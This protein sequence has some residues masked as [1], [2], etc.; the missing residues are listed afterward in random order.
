LS[1]KLLEFSFEKKSS[2]KINKNKFIQNQFV[3]FFEKNAV[4]VEQFELQADLLSIIEKFESSKFADRYNVQKDEDDYNK[5]FIAAKHD[6][7]N[8]C[9]LQST[10]K[11]LNSSTN[12]ND[13]GIN[14]NYNINISLVL[15]DQN[16]SESIESSICS[17]AK[18]NF[19][20]KSFFKNDII[21]DQI[22]SLNS[23]AQED[24]LGSL[25]DNSLSIVTT[26]RTGDETSVVA[27]YDFN[28]EKDSDLTF[29]KGDRIQ[30]L[31][32]QLNGWWVGRNIRTLKCGYFPSNFITNK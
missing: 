25:G 2:E 18:N 8:S 21:G 28:A 29:E 7:N 27:A 19:K 17:A 10:S 6:Y 14:S 20:L 9:Q 32:R 22:S 4:I 12:S 5:D 26:N 13:V 1:K 31:E 16:T 23:S 30:V 3:D 24:I 15:K 11:K